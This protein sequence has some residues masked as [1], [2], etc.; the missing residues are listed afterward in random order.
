MAKMSKLEISAWRAA[1]RRKR[2]TEMQRKR[3][4][5]L[6]LETI[7]NKNKSKTTSVSM[8]SSDSTTANEAPSTCMNCGKQ[9]GKQPIFCWFARRFRGGP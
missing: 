2:K 5:E 3:R 1:Q 4:K 7:N 6:K 8:T 9:C